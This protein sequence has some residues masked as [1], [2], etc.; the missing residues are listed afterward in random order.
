MKAAPTQNNSRLMRG[1]AAI[2][3][4]MALNHLG[5]RLLGI[6]I[7]VFTGIAYFSPL[8]IVDVFVLPLACGILVSVIYGMGGKWLCYFPP[9]IVRAISYYEVANITGVP[10]G[11]ALM[12]LGWWGFFVIL[13]V[14]AAVIGGV[15]GE[16]MMKRTYGRRARHL[17]YKDRAPADQ[18]NPGA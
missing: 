4:A 17:V 12:P 5:D 13:V 9:M 18:E 14:E 10:Q 7:E 16:V 3:M 8:W 11:A 15:L 1:A 6:N 2:L